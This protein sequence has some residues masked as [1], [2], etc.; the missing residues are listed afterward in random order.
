MPG[1]MVMG[2]SDGVVVVPRKD[3]ERIMTQ[4]EQKLENEK[5]RIAEIDRGKIEPVWLK[6]KL[7]SMGIESNN[8]KNNLELS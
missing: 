3:I 6:D 1:D 5:V 4:A 2:V 7:L 8:W